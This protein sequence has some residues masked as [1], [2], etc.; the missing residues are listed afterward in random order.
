MKT[1][2]VLGV[3]AAFLSLQGC[4]KNV[5]TL[6]G[7]SPPGVSPIECGAPPADNEWL[8]VTPEGDA[9]LYTVDID[10]APPEHP[11]ICLSVL[12][13]DEVVWT[14]EKGKAKLRFPK[15]KSKMAA[16]KD[17][18]KGKHPSDFRDMHHSSELNEK[19]IGCR[20]ELI[21][22]RENAPSTDPHI[23]IGGKGGT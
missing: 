2:L 10:K 8:K 9:Y 22:E 13:G 3:A 15:Y 14:H 18:F 17:P 7:S 20:Y 21:F 23:V 12:H 19:M 6:G 4:T 16:C 11:E 5:K 1:V